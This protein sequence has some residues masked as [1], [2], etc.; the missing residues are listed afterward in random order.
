MD[1]RTIVTLTMGQTADALGLQVM[2]IGGTTMWY[3]QDKPPK[4][5]VA[6]NFTHDGQAEPVSIVGQESWESEHEVMG[7]RYRI[8]SPYQRDLKE[9]ELEVSRSVH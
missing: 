3:G 7:F 5:A 9:L 2:F 4:G 1:E 6:L 8:L